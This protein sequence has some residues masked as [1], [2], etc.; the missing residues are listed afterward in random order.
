M[1][2]CREQKAAFHDKLDQHG[3]DVEKKHE[4]NRARFDKID[5]TIYIATG[6][7]LAAAWA[8]SHGGEVLA[9]LLK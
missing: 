4:E 8:F 9:K 3:D 6:A 5:R 2:E 1:I 7:A